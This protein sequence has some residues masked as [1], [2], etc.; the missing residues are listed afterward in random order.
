MTSP[1]LKARLVDQIGA[2]IEWSRAK[3][4]VNDELDTIGHVRPETLK[5]MR[6]VEAR[7]EAVL[8]I[9]LARIPE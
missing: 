5:R 1:E 8:A 3:Q 6:Q 4:A 7:G 2:I 9:Q